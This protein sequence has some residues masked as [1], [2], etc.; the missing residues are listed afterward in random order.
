MEKKQLK[1]QLPEKPEENSEIVIEFELLY[2]VIYIINMF[3]TLA[4]IDI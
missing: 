2:L 4:I 1:L 3:L